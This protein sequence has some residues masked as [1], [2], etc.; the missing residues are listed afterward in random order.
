MKNI[1][2][3]IYLPLFDGFYGTKFE[4]NFPCK[5][6]EIAKVIY[7]E[8]VAHL[9]RLKLIESAKYQEV[10]SPREYN[11]ANDE[12]HLSVNINEEN[13]N[14]IM[15][16]IEEDFSEFQGKI[17]E[18]FTSYPGFTSFY[19]ND[20]KDWT[21]EIIFTDVVMLSTSLEYCLEYSGVTSEEIGEDLES[22]IEGI[23]VYLEING[24]KYSFDSDVFDTE[25]QW[26]GYNDSDNGTQLW[27]AV[28]LDPSPDVLETKEDI[29][30]FI[31][32][33]F[34]ETGVVL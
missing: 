11:Y 23:T 10:Y 21:E 33:V 18:N 3:D 34:E 22:E 14:N 27:E 29:D 28:Y 2:M 6:E 4:H 13:K 20:A 17:G 24:T 32:E 16:L 19:S 12:I 9:I 8:V 7:E 1:E 25:G 31:K 5:T 26:S 15:R 30:E